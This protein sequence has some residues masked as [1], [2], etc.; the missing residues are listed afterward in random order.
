[1]PKMLCETTESFMLIDFTVNEEIQ[2]YRPSVVRQTPFFAGHVA[3][4]NIKILLADVDEAATDEEFVDLWK[5]D[6]KQA[7][8]RFM[9]KYGPKREAPA[10]VKEQSKPSK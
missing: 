4:G 6:R 7:V 1:M 2:A 5:A 8:T 9:A 3:R 10:P